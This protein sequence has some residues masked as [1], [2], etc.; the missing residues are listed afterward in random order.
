[1]TDGVYRGVAHVAVY[2]RHEHPP[3]HVG[4]LELGDHYCELVDGLG[5]WAKK[6]SKRF[7]RTW[8]LTVKMR[9]TGGEEGL[10]AGPSSSP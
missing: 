2:V 1:M 8:P 7:F 9:R 5:I 6:Q 10:S 4:L 3:G